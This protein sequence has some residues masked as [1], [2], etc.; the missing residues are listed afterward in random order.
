MQN[1]ELKL[2]LDSD[3]RMDMREFENNGC[4]CLVASSF[5]SFALFDCLKAIA[6]LL[7]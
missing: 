5:C 6:A 2:M 4:T 1:Y 3:T 7:N